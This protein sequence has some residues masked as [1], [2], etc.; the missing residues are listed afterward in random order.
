VK[1]HVGEADHPQENKQDAEEAVRQMR[2]AV[3]GCGALYVPILRNGCKGF[4]A[5]N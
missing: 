5:Q 3:C 2:Q 1:H 4:E